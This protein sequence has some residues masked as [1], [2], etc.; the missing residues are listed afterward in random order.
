MIAGEDATTGKTFDR[1]TF[2]DKN[3]NINPVTGNVLRPTPFID[4]GV[5]FTV[6]DGTPLPQLDLDRVFILSTDGTCS[7]SEAVI[8]GLRGIDVEVILIGSQTC[9]K[10]YGF[11]SGFGV[12]V[13][14]CTIAD[15]FQGVLGDEN[16]PFLA[17]A[18]QFAA[19]GTC[20]SAG[21]A[22]AKTS[23]SYPETSLYP[24]FDIM[25]DKR[26]QMDEFMSTSRILGV[27]DG[28]I[29]DLKK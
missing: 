24:E 18:L 21:T 15:N 23:V 29:A 13:P 4:T 25:N 6:D 16:E 28:D 8:N 14:G 9:G 26:V 2:N 11:S 19:D 22:N 5:G 1:L 12:E 10:P 3:P 17:A 20:P 27:T 7:A